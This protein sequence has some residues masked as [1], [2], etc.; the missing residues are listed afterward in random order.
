[1]CRTFSPAHYFLPG[2]FGWIQLLTRD[3]NSPTP[4]PTLT[5]TVTEIDAM[6][7]DYLRLSSRNEG[8]VPVGN[9]TVQGQNVRIPNAH[10]YCFSHHAFNLWSAFTKNA[11]AYGT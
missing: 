4:F 3:K 9:V 2:I 10:I 1:L 7:K 8:N 5:L 6:S 11:S